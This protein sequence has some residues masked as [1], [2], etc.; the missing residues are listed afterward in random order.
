MAAVWLGVLVLAL[1]VMALPAAAL[2]QSSAAVN[3][4]SQGEG[5]TPGCFWGPGEENVGPINEPDETYPYRGLAPDTDTDYYATTF[6]LAPG[7]TVTLHGQFPHARFFSLTT[8]KNLN[9]E[10]GIPA[11]SVVDENVV[12]DAGSINP[13]T[14]G[15]SRNASNRAF[16]ITIS[17]ALQP[18]EPAPNT[19]YVGQEGHTEETQNVEVIERIYRADR[20]LEANGGVPLPAPTYNPTEGSPVSNESA[21]CSDLS[22]VSGVESIN[23]TK[24][25]VPPAT[26]KALRSGLPGTKNRPHIRP[27]IRFAGKSSSTAGI[28]SH[29]STAAPPTNLRSPA[30]A[31]P[32]P[33]GSMRRPPTRMQSAMRVVCSGQTPKVTTSSCCT[34]KCRRIP[35]PTTAT[36]PAT[37]AAR[38][39]AI[40]RC[41]TTRASPK[42][43]CLQ[44]T[45]AACL[46]KRY[47]QTQTANTRSS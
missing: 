8:Y 3:P 17:G 20:G 12:P 7:A 21:L 43:R 1:A 10:P 14:A 47:R 2:G 37:T 45:P 42:G 9:G 46:T 34:P 36:R 44:R 31:R 15:E 24:F 26:Y 29:R 16:T 28:W 4:G 19:L 32:P 27:P 23:E 39:S 30:S 5:P 25:G 38:R 40:G 33:P 41:A 35:K 18:A 6:K 22:V 11:D 13:F